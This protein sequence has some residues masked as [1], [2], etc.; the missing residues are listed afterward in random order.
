MK[1]KKITTY[2]LA[3]ACAA[4]FA[5]CDMDK[6]PYDRIPVEN[7]VTNLSDCQNLRS[8]SRL[9]R[10]HCQPREFLL[11]AILMDDGGQRR[12]GYYRMVQ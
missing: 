12:Y 7:A 1:T 5:S 3:T 8:A 4:V 9:H 6:Y 2:L 11:S 10:A